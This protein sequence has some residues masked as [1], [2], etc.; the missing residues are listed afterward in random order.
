M[1]YISVVPA[2]LTVLS[3]FIFSLGEGR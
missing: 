1:L 3:Y 2:V